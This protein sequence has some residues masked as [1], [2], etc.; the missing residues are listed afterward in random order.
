MGADASQVYALEADLAAAPAQ[1]TAEAVRAVDHNTDEMARDARE[2]APVLTG[3]LRARIRA[4]SLG[5]TGRVVSEADYGGYVEHGTSDTPAQ[6]YMR[7]ASELAGPRLADDLGDIGED[8][9]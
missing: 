9:L 5:L 3:N 6:P 1:V 8:I 2:F 7:P 4:M